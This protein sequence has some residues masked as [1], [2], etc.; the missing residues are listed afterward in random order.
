MT[1]NIIRGIIAVLLLG[2]LT[3]S[4]FQKNNP[5]GR[6][7]KENTSGSDADP[8]V[9]DSADEE[10]YSKV[11]E[12]IKKTSLSP[13]DSP[14][15]AHYY[16]FTLENIDGENVSLSD[17]EG[18]TILLNFWA[19]WCGPCLREMPSMLELYKELKDEDFVI[20]AVDIKDDKTDVK[21]YVAKAGLTFPVLLDK[22]TEIAGI[23][24]AASIP[25][26]YLIDTKGYIVGYALGSIYWHTEEIK[27]TIMFIKN[28]G[29]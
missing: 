7:E 26:S 29:K 12:I 28:R 15:E 27:E 2:V 3:G 19:L 9:V 1:G 16:D 10:F 23:Y 17:F 21:K 13:Y 4:C 5:A 24:G 8:V 11:K 6:L 18:Q 14:L 22:T 25:L 20:I